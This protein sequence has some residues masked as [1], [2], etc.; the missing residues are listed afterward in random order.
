V[1]RAIAGPYM[2]LGATSKAN[3]AMNAHVTL[4]HQFIINSSSAKED[5]EIL[6]SKLQLFSNQRNT[7]TKCDVPA[8]MERPG[9]RFGPTRQ[10]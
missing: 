9:E 1:R 8:L 6:G 2:S 4:K 7:R 5:C 3:L 10:P